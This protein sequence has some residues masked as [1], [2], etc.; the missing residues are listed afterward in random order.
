MYAFAAGLF[1]F[2]GFPVSCLIKRFLYES[3]ICPFQTTENQD[4]R[5][6][7]ENQ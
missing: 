5:Q 6:T 7:L 1:L 3:S 2:T 4:F